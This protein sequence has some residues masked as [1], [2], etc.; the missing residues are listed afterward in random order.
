MIATLK[1]TLSNSQRFLPLF[2]TVLLFF[3]VYSAGAVAYDP[4]RSPQVF[5][6]LFRNT[7]FLLISAVG[8]TFVIITGHDP[9]E[10]K[11]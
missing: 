2:A 1:T 6:N 4:M 5:L 11:H 9:K 7:P 3:I 8:M 10:V